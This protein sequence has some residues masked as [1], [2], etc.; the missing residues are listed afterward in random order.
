MKPGFAKMPEVS[1]EERRQNED[2][3]HRLFTIRARAEV[4]L[5]TLFKKG[6]HMND[7]GITAAV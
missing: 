4:L 2:Y 1:G 3:A 6:K 5:G 7:Q